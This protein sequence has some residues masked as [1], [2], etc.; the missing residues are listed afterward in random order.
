VE[1]QV[2]TATDI[3]DKSDTEYDYVDI[4]EW[5]GRVKIRSLTADEV[6]KFTESMKGEAKKNAMVRICHL[7]TV[8]EDGSPMFEDGNMI[9]KLQKKSVKAIN[10]IQKAALKLNGMDDE[11]KAQENAKND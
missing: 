1:D 11:A 6:I 2:L 10:R 9:A 5:G 3:L 8:N 7:C 4:P